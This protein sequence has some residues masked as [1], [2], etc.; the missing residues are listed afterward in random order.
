MAALVLVGVHSN[1][2]HSRSRI[3][4]SA[5][6]PTEPQPTILRVDANGALRGTVATET[7]ADGYWTARW[8]MPAGTWTFIARVDGYSHNT[9]AYSRKVVVKRI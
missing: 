2:D 8:T 6:N 4:Q 1:A 9:T 7:T 5:A 3:S